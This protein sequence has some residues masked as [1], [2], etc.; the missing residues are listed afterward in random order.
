MMLGGMLDAGGVIP[1]TEGV[2]GG[3]GESQC[4]K[5]AWR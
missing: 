1:D 3:G 5:D 2:L 4:W